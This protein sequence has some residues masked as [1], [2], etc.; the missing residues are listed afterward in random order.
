MAANTRIA[1]SPFDTTNTSDVI[2]RTHDGVDFYVHKP[3]LSMVSPFFEQ[4]FSLEQP[5]SPPPNRHAVVVVSEGSEAIDGI[6]RLCYPVPEPNMASIPIV[7]RLVV[8]AQKYDMQYVINKLKTPLRGFLSTLPLQ[9]FALAGRYQI[10][11]I[12]NEAALAWRHGLYRDEEQYSEEGYDQSWDGTA[13]AQSYIT[14][15]AD[16][17]SGMYF[18]LVRY[19][20]TNTP[21]GSYC[22]PPR[23]RS[24]T[25]DF[26]SVEP[27]LPLEHPLDRYGSSYL[28]LDADTDVIISSID[29]VKFPA[30]RMILSA[31]S[32][33]LR[34]LLVTTEQQQSETVNLAE[35]GDALAIVL[36]S[37][38]PTGTMLEADIP[39]SVITSVLGAAV[40]YKLPVLEDAAKRKL[41]EYTLSQ[42]LEVYLRA[43]NVGWKDGARTAAEH[44][45]RLPNSDLYHPLMETTP[46]RYY[47]A[48]L[49]F[50]FEYRRALV[51]C[52]LFAYRYRSQVF[53][54]DYWQ[55]WMWGNDIDQ[56]HPELTV[57]FAVTSGHRAE[58]KVFE[59]HKT[60]I[61]SALSQVRYYTDRPRI[62]LLSVSRFNSTLNETV[63]THPPACKEV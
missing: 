59:G 3:I 57:A 15:M 61:L 47:H 41:G 7:M 39:L 42:P 35:N 31:A 52:S 51:G 13:V 60:S 19:L 14:E 53:R 49:K 37:C 22:H 21:P 50:H 9:V 48:V 10:E 45:S 28:Q 38:Y 23:A 1:N 62:S 24:C 32:R 20:R 40:K 16:I 11:D 58:S 34:G 26:E 30:H 8:V 44:L 36:R 33:V 54:G 43:V 29:G 56:I 63:L 2:I 17:P 4:M 12:A 25:P 6:L 18:R 46:A 27:A 5:P 55:A